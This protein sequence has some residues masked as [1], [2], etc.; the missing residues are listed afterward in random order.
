MKRILFLIMLAPIGCFCQKKISPVF[1]LGAGWLFYPGAS[2]DVHID[3]TKTGSPLKSG[4]TLE[5]NADQPVNSFL[6]LGLGAS[7]I[8]FKDLENPYIPVFADI[9]VVGHGTF[10]F[11]SFLNPGYGIYHREVQNL[12]LFIDPPPKGTLSGGFFIA[13]GF[14]VI[15]KKIYLQAKY[16]WLRFATK[17]DNYKGSPIGFKTQSHAYGVAGLTFGLHLP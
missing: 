1:Q 6:R 17:P 13:Y 12:A 2:D 4:Y 16:N 9:R 10:K 11:Y 15:Y 3:G 5:F 14:G 7:L 8:Q